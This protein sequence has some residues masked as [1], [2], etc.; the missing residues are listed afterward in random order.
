M[1]DGELGRWLHRNAAGVVVEPAL[2]NAIQW[3]RV[4]LMDASAI[5]A[6]GK[7]DVVLCRN[8]LIYFS[9]DTTRKLAA[10]LAE[11]LAPE[12]CLLLGVSESL[13]RLGTALTC[14]ERGGVFLYR[15]TL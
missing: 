8:V 1:P 12:G 3:R 4:N 6:L 11:S 5:R 15:S 9:D 7:F 2:T 13:M 14:E 10:N